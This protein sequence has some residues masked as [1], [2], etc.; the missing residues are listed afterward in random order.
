[1]RLSGLAAAAL[2]AAAA[3]LGPRPAAAQVGVQWDPVTAWLPRLFPKGNANGGAVSRSGNI[4]RSPPP[5]RPEISGND[6]GRLTFVS[7]HSSGGNP[8]AASG[9][10]TAASVQ[11]RAKPAIKPP[12]KAPKRATTVRGAQLPAA[13]PPPTQLPASFGS[14][15]QTTQQLPEGQPEGRPNPAAGTTAGGRGADGIAAAKAAT[16]MP[17]G[18]RGT[19]VGA[20]SGK[21]SAAPPPPSPKSTGK[22][23]GTFATRGATRETT[24][25]LAACKSLHGLQVMQAVR[26]AEGPLSLLSVG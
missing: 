23:G 17:A 21:A 9:A 15:A 2:V 20:A 14:A 16:T 1:M 6:A 12:T 19:K 22:T 25:T 18:V 3:L 11:K 24:G 10:K 8:S 13:S 7:G 5:P 26:R 4:E